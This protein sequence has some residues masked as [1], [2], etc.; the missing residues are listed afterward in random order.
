MQISLSLRAQVNEENKYV[1][2]NIYDQMPEPKVVVAIG[3]C[4][5]S[6]V[7]SGNV[8]MSPGE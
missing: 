5:T 8:T 2:K 6:G 7:S 1:V 4:A 3:I